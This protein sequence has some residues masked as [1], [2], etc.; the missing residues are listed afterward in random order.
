MLSIRKLF[1]I[2]LLFQLQTIEKEGKLVFK[3][4]HGMTECVANKVHACALNVIHDQNL[5]L[6]IVSCMINDNM[7]P[8]EAGQKVTYLLIIYYLS[9]T[10]DCID[11]SVQ[12][13]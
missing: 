9:V 3:C 12:K 6:K 11:F 5:Q 7:I 13:I 10:I 4:Q 2:I 1:C 8:H